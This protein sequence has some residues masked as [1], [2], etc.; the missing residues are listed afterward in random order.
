MAV[1]AEK[2][3]EEHTSY[4]D[5]GRTPRRMPPGDRGQ[6]R[7]KQSP[8]GGAVHKETSRPV[9]QKRVLDQLLPSIRVIGSILLIFAMAFGVV[10]SRAAISDRGY[11]M[12][13]LRAELEDAKG[14]TDAMESRLARLQDPARIA[15]AA[16]DLGMV[17]VSHV[18]VTTMA[19]VLADDVQNPP[20]VSVGSTALLASAS[21]TAPD[22]LEMPGQK[23]SSTAFAAPSP[24]DDTR[25]VLE[26]ERE[27]DPPLQFTEARELGHRVLE[28]LKGNAP[29][30]AHELP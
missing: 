20:S 4:P 1:T 30:E 24:E 2:L 15:A 27:L 5:P 26:L 6:K 29:V 9:N 13:R 14:E 11:E 28:W 19:P 3:R 25:V 16:D 22:P 23:P 17:P 8:R 7:S 10:A 18:P 12:V 21:S